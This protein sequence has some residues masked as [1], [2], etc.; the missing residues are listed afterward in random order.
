MCHTYGD[1]C[2]D[3]IKRVKQRHDLSSSHRIELALCDD[4]TME[5]DGERHEDE[6]EELLQADT[7]HVNM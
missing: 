1:Q 3:R 7:A 5:R 4:R 6:D 2:D